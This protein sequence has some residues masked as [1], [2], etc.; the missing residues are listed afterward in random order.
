[1][2]RISGRLLRLASHT[3]MRCLIPPLLTRHETSH[4]EAPL[5]RRSLD[6]QVLIGDNILRQG[7]YKLI[8]GGG[9]NQTSGPGWAQG[10]LRDCMLGTGGGLTAA[11]KLGAGLESKCPMTSY[12]K[13][14]PTIPCLRIPSLTRPWTGSG[15]SQLRRCGGVG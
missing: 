11:V 14:M 15:R 4:H 7:K 5:Q 1:M 2:A 13:A 9:F 6:P 8:A 10:F 3:V 12:D